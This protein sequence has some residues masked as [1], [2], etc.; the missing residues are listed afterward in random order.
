[1]LMIQEAREE[2]EEEEEEREGC[3]VPSKQPTPAGE[4]VSGALTKARQN[5]ITS[6]LLVHVRLLLP[7]K[8][9]AAALNISMPCI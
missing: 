5:S 8:D 9:L 1:M 6:C 2:A 7:C 3:H 4:V